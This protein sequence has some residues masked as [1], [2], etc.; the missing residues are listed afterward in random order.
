MIDKNLELAYKAL[1]EWKQNITVKDFVED[2]KRLNSKPNINSP[3]LSNFIKKQE[4]C[5]E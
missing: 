4:L 3:N 5:D 1:K 2:N